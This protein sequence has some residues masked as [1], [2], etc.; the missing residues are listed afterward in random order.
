MKSILLGFAGLAAATGVAAGLYVAV[1]DGGEEEVLQDLPTASAEATATQPAPVK[2]Q[3][4][5]WVNVTV[6]VPE[7]SPVTIGRGTVPQG[8]KGEG[9]PG[10]DLTIHHGGDP[11]AAS[12]VVIEAIT[13]EVVQ[14][15]VF[16]DDRPTIDEVLGTLAVTSFDEAEKGWPYADEIP[17]DVERRGWGG[18]SYV[19]PDPDAGVTVGVEID[20][21]G[22]S[23]I[24]ISNGRS[25]VGIT[26]DSETGGLLRYPAA[27]SLQDES[28]FDR[29]IEAIQVCGQE[30]KC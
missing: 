7:G 8:L 19:L 30:I 22:G 6:V 12:F 18:M 13:G 28:A 17:A 3:L 2:G 9:D 5:R 21:P 4:W 24:V 23:F 11:E 10:M 26:V 1:P 29:Y 27:L 14:D 16:D 25:R 20:D 15:H